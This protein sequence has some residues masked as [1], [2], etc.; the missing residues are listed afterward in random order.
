MSDQEATSALAPTRSK[1]TSQLPMAMLIDTIKAHIGPARLP[2]PRVISR[3]G[4][5]RIAASKPRHDSHHAVESNA[6]S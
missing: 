6:Q 1:Q 2:G 5:K 4:S 3:L